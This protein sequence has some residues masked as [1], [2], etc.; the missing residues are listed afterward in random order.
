MHD[1]E[2]RET[3]D[4]GAGQP[5]PTQREDELATTNRAQEEDSMRGARDPEDAA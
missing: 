1:D 5:E 4:S 3:D 2:P